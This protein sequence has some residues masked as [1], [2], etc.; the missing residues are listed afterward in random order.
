M[1]LIAAYYYY[2]C[3]YY[4]YYYYHYY[5]YNYYYEIQQEEGEFDTQDYSGGDASIKELI[6]ISEE[7]RRIITEILELSKSGGNNPDNFKKANQHQLV[8]IT[9]RVNKVID[10]IPTRTITEQSH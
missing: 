6:D 5:Y 9:N 10:K 7:D 1:I 4:Y 3:Y 8:E 2:Y